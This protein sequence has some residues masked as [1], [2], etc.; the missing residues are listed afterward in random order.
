MGERKIYA[1]LR[2]DEMI[3]MRHAEVNGL[4]SDG[5]IDYLEKEFGWLEASG[6]HLAKAFISDEDDAN[7]WC[8]YIDYLVSWAFAH[9]YEEHDFPRAMT[10]DEWRIENGR[11]E[12]PLAFK[13][14]FPLISPEDGAKMLVRMLGKGES[15]IIGDR[16]SGYVA[17]ATDR[18]G[19]GFVKASLIEEAKDLY[20]EDA[21]YALH[22]LDDIDGTDGRLVRTAR[23][24]TD[25]LADLLK[26]VL[27][28]LQE[29]RM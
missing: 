3:A 2:V 25:E 28:A 8:C 7:D 10:Y 4:S 9:T 23:L 21:G 5:T 11:T 15:T 20:P 1:E 26:E 12:S 13:K 17:I 14:K 6:I 29:G 24:D 22:I 19:K 27:E 16:T 18:T